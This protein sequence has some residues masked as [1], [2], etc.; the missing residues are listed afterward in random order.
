MNACSQ[1]TQGLRLVAVLAATVLAL[2]HDAGGQV[3][4]THRRVGLVD[5]LASG[6]AGAVGVNAQVGRV[7]LDGLRLIGFGQHRNGAGAGVDTTL[8]FGGWHALHT[9]AARFKL[10]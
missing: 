7:D 4:D 3:G 8:C 10:E 5:V 2:G 1:H 6:T 9:M